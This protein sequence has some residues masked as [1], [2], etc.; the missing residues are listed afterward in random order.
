MR[1]F[2]LAAFQLFFSLPLEGGDLPFGE[3]Q[4]FFGGLLLK[5][6]QAPLGL[7]RFGSMDLA[8]IERG[9]V[10]AWRLG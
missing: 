5:R 9:A 3:H 4:A 7:H 10:T 2:D 6:C 1:C 8:C